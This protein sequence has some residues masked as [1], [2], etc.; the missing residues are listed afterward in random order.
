MQSFYVAL[1]VIL[2]FFSSGVLFKIFASMLINDIGFLFSFLCGIS[3]G[4]GITVMAVSQ[5][6][7]QSVTLLA[8]FEKL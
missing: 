3:V 1:R 7:F 5:I 2:F 8:V 4:F 6:G